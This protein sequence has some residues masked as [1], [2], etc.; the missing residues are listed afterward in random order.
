M[1]NFTP[2]RNNILFTFFD[3]VYSR[4]FLE[5]T[6][7]GIVIA[8]TFDEALNKGRWARVEMVGP[9]VPSDI[10]IGAEV[11]IEPLKWTEKFQLNGKIYWQTNSDHIMAI[12]DEN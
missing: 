7:S 9:D 8:G 4:Q 6:E 12:N 3:Q 2:L 1:T 10:T 11:L 5:K